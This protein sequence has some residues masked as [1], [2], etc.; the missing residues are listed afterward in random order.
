M[1]RVNW[2]FGGERWGILRPHPSPGSK[3]ISVVLSHWLLKSNWEKLIMSYAGCITLGWKLYCCSKQGR[4][5]LPYSH[6]VVCIV[7]S[8]P[9]LKITASYVVSGLQREDPQLSG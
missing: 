7:T 3:A 8:L 9:N 2:K 6:S 5:W 4:R 1:I